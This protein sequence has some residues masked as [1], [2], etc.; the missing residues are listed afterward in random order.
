MIVLDGGSSLNYYFKGEHHDYAFNAIPFR[1]LWF[2]QNA[3]FYL[4]GYKE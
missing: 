1:D 2:D 4:E 3:P